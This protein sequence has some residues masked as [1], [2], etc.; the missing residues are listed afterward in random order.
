[1]SE[2]VL[3]IYLFLIS[4]FETENLIPITVFVAW[5]SILPLSPNL[6]K[7]EVQKG[8]TVFPSKLFA[9]TKMSTVQTGI[10][11]QIGYPIITCH[12]K[13]RELEYKKQEIQDCINY[14]H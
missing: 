9:L 12:T 4:T 5:A 3:S 6:L 7:A 2:T 14:I 13:L 8:I 1:M 11:H 10:P